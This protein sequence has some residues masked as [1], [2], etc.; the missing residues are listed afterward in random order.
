MSLQKI[1]P[2]LLSLSPQ[3]KAQA[4]QLLVASLSHTWIGIEKTPGVM[5]GEACIRQTR[6]SVWLLASLRQQGATDADLLED[7]PTLTATDLANAWVYA[8]SYPNEIASAIQQQ[9][10]A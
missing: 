2:H 3:E 5:G 8:D 7:Y 10:A 9:K 1:Q 4:I 6:I